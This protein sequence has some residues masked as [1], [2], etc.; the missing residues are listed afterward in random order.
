[1]GLGMLFASTGT[2]FW[3]EAQCLMEFERVNGLWLF[4]GVMMGLIALD[5]Q[6]RRRRAG[7]DERR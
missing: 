3:N 5:T 4:L 1:M 6:R 7:R 2:T